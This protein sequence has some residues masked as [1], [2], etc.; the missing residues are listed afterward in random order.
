M[1]SAWILD[2]YCWIHCEPS[3]KCTREGQHTTQLLRPFWPSS[4][5]CYLC[6]R[7]VWYFFIELCTNMEL[8]IYLSFHLCSYDYWSSEHRSKLHTEKIDV[9]CGIAAVD[10]VMSAK[11]I[12]SNITKIWQW[13][14]WLSA[15]LGCRFEI[16]VQHVALSGVFHR[17]E[18]ANIV[19]PRGA[20]QCGATAHLTLN[21]GTWKL[22]WE[23][24]VL[25]SVKLYIIQFNASASWN[26]PHLTGLPLFSIRTTD[27]DSTHRHSDFIVRVKRKLWSH[28]SRPHTIMVKISHQTLTLFPRLST[29]FLQL[30]N[31]VNVIPKKEQAIPKKD[32]VI[33]LSHQ[34]WTSLHMSGQK[35]AFSLL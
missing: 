32:I 34:K 12:P 15:D 35:L 31:N 17:R 2:C 13:R 10:V 14:R 29:T 27:G 30:P 7:S 25:W 22:L 4:F 23:F 19:E 8:I 1:Q 26:F 20:F 18:Q 16:V 11:K 24:L 33:R 5:Y 21:S 6:I 28:F 3:T 9:T